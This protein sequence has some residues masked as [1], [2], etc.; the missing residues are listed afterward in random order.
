MISNNQSGGQTALVINNNYTNYYRDSIPDSTN[1]HFRTLKYQGQ[2][3]LEV[4]PRK[5]AWISPF[6]AEGDS[7]IRPFIV[8]NRSDGATY[9]RVN[10]DANFIYP[11]FTGF[12][13]STPCS[14]S[15]PMYILLK[16]T[17]NECHFWGDYNDFNKTYYY[18]QGKVFWKTRTSTQ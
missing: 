4:F 11:H 10:L 17:K 15:N 1:Y 13:R 9:T 18:H 8:E 7:I 5:G 3:Y 14:E 16:E 12:Y 2:K 6:Y